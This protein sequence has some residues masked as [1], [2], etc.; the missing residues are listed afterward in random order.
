MRK[1]WNEGQVVHCLRGTGITL[2][3]MPA[4]RLLQG[5]STSARSMHPSKGLFVYVD[6]ENLPST[7]GSTQSQ[8]IFNPSWT[9][10]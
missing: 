9:T 3:W 8:N 10:T 6:G 2:L 5:S 1:L 7:T 4:R